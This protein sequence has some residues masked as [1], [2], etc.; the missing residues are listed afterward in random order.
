M[1]VRSGF[2]LAVASAIFTSGSPY[3]PVPNGSDAT[4]VIPSYAAS[5]TAAKLKIS[6]TYKGSAQ[7]Q[8]GSNQFSASLRM[9]IR[10][11]GKKISG[12]FVLTEGS[13]VNDLSIDGN[14]TSESGK[15]ATLRFELVNGKGRSAQASATIDGKNLKGVGNVPG[16]SS[17]PSVYIT[18]SA[19][20]KAK[21]KKPLV[22]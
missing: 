15:K 21:H 13:K 10:Q 6:G 11:H 8:E 9:T 19:K 4:P 17:K 22:L 2:A 12:V 7:W 3:Q 20:K 16:S 5:S 18:F 1:K 14:V